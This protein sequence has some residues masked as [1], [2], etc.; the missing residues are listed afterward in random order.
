MYATSHKKSAVKYRYAWDYE[1][2]PPDAE[3]SHKMTCVRCGFAMYM[4]EKN[5]T[6][7]M[8]YICKLDYVIFGKMGLPLYRSK[9]IGSGDGVCTMY[10]KLNEEIPNVGFDD[11]YLKQFISKNAD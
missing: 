2:E 1:Y 7:F 4:E 10:F 11:D 6:E 3:Y 8:P 5:L 9:T